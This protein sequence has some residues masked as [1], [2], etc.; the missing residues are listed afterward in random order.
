MGAASPVRSV[1]P[2]LC[3]VA[4]GVVGM[5]CYATGVEA[6]LTAASA[7]LLWRGALLFLGDLLWASAW[8]QARSSPFPRGG[9]GASGP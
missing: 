3:V 2:G 1:I 7:D 6:H 5:A 8:W 4:V 9:M